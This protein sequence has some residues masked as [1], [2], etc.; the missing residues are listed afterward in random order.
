MTEDRNVPQKDLDIIKHHDEALK[1]LPRDLVL[2]VVKHIRSRMT[3]ELADQIRF[4]HEENQATWW[5]P[6]H[7]TWGMSVR[8]S[9][10][11]NVAIDKVT[12]SNNWDDYYVPLIELAVGIRALEDSHGA[13]DV[14]VAPN[15]G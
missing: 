6:I 11:N 4:D 15:D 10:R 1:S 3:L 12:P 9:I 2:R 14:K 7:H 8:N 13:G 5:A